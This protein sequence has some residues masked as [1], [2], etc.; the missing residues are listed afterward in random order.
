[1]IGKRLL[2]FMRFLR[3]VGF[4]ASHSHMINAMEAIQEVGLKR[5]DAKNALKVTLCSNEW[6]WS[7]FDRLFESYFGHVQAK[8]DLKE[9][10]QVHSFNGPE[11]SY[12][13]AEEKSSHSHLKEEHAPEE[14]EK[15]ISAFSIL[16]G[17]GYSPVSFLVKKEIQAYSP[18]DV[19][20]AQLAIR[21]I[22]EPFK[23]QR[24]RRHKKGNGRIWDMRSTL[25]DA[26][27]HYGWPMRLYSLEKKKR[28]KRMLIIADV[29]GS[30]QRYNAMVLPFLLSLKG[31]GPKAEVF[32]FST[33]V[34]R[35][36]EIIRHL[37]LDKA[38]NKIIADVQDWSGGTRIG[39]SLQ[40]IN[41]NYDKKL[42]NKRAVVLIISDG[43]DL[44]AKALLLREMK[45]LRSRV[46]KILWLNP[47]AGDPSLQIMSQAVKLCMD[48]ID[49]HI[50]AAS[51]MDLSKVGLLLKRLMSY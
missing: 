40:H 49:Y 46:N 3:E 45:S 12:E 4:K 36:T 32:V 44:G 15:T 11:E 21:H 14:K 35:I 43:W 7:S 33:K 1:V 47:I 8:K 10:P 27:R 38:L 19:Q 2:G 34:Q 28:L 22:M 50:P 18:E 26:M 41:R 31:V 24:A 51:L 17:L 13:A 48:Y 16:A 39:E 20:M 25:R 42:L 6:E 5:P 29:S 9:L 30:M 37:P 23:I